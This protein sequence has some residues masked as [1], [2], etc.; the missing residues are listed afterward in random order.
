MRLPSVKYDTES[1]SA[2]KERFLFAFTENQPLSNLRLR[3][4]KY[5]FDRSA[6]RNMTMVDNRHFIADRLYH[7]HLMRDDNDGYAHFPI[8]FL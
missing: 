8:D 3:G 5:F 1:S 6:L 2:A 7:A 4:L